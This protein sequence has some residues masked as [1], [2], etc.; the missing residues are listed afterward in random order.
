MHLHPDSA[1]S[2]ALAVALGVMYNSQ[3]V[4]CP[5]YKPQHDSAVIGDSTV[6]HTR[7]TTC[8]CTCT[9]LTDRLSLRHRFTW[10]CS[11][12]R[13]SHN[14]QDHTASRVETR[15]IWDRR[16][17]R[18][19]DGR[20]GGTFSP[21]CGGGSTRKLRMHST[22]TSPRLL[23]IAVLLHGSSFFSLRGRLHS[24]RPRRF[25]SA[26]RP[27]CPIPDGRG[28]SVSKIRSRILGL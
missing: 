15:W 25:S 24:H 19:D 16:E 27:A 6:P 17:R 18:A 13:R 23:G 11:H 28:P 7:H 10:T 14:T 5:I 12:P 2:K 4:A 9:C 26:A 20:A 3:S 8:T 1:T 21:P 22:V